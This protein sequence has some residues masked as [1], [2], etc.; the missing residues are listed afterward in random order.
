MTIRKPIRAVAIVIR[1][2]QVLLMWRKLHGHEYY[3]LPGGGV[4]GEETVEEAVLREIQEE[5]SLNIKIDNSIS[6]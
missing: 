4:E 6:M 5:T 1:D 3:V 2:K